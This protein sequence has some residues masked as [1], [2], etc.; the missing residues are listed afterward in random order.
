MDSPTPTTNSGDSAA[1][2]RPLV[3]D[4][5]GTLIK[6]DLLVE[7]F[8]VLLST[9]P[10][11]GPDALAA[12]RGGRAAFKARVAEQ[13]ALDVASLPLNPQLLAYLQAEK[14]R[15]RRLVLASAAH[16]SYA[17]AIAAHTGLF[18]AV[19]A[20]DGQTN[21]KG[22]AK[23]RALCAAFGQGGF[24][25]AGNSPADLEVWKDAGG[26]VAV[27]ASP[28]LIRTVKARFPGAVILDPRATRLQDYL[29]AIRVHQ[30]LKNLLIFV[31]A[32]TAHQFDVPT[33][34]ACFAAFASFSLGAS[35]LYLLN[36]L[37][38]LRNDRAH[39]TKR[40]RPFAAGTLDLVAGI[41]LCFAT[42]LV[43]TLIG[44][45]LPWK[46]LAVLAAYYT[47]S[48][49]YSVFLKR[50]PTIDVLTLACLYGIRLLAGAVAISV[51]LSPWLLMFSIFFFLCL[52]LV[53]RSTEL[54]D[55]LK[56]GAGDPPGR[57]Y[58]LDDLPILQ[59]MASTSGYVSVLVFVLYVNSPTV[60][61][62]YAS[63]EKLWLIPM[64]LL[65]WISR[66]MI[67]TQRGEMHDDPV[68]FAARDRT[69]LVCAGLMA[70]IVL[71]SI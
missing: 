61:A 69:S 21:L 37:L 33:A 56:K 20:S 39:S 15:G 18:D 10:L 19:F 40:H 11:R 52:A 14:A 5:D 66:I 7:S 47:L 29:Q 70:L 57:S 58:R 3:V 25:Y 64:I 26:V 54:I 17:R 28:G 4:L 13:V 34:L 12:L 9:M 67:L 60:A 49:G 23:S 31:P 32:F 35:G 42:V 53:K 2:D 6:S 62:L 50:Q 46:F 55:R 63:P 22:A 51:A 45:V 38:D 30:W 36:D 41:R 27:N 43:S 68:L 71:A 48:A 24:D 44:L 16:E 1:I 65:Y 8:S 59:T